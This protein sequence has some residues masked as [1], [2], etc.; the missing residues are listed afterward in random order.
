MSGVGWVGDERVRPRATAVACSGPAPLGTGPADL[1]F[2]AERPGTGLGAGLA[3]LS[4][5][6]P[7]DGLCA[8]MNGAVPHAKIRAAGHPT[9]L[10]SVPAGDGRSA[11]VG[12]AKGVW[13]YAVL[14]PAAA[15]YLLADQVFLHDLA[16]SMPSELV[17]GAPSPHLCPTA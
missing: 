3:G 2:V 14:W 13:L 15:G 9:P 7:G 5:P 8:A 10:W 11:Y 17:F 6:D 4:G 12:A 1:V 16:E